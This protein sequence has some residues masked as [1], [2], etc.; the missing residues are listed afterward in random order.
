MLMCTGCSYRNALIKRDVKA[1]LTVEKCGSFAP[2]LRP[3][4]PRRM[5]AQKPTKLLH[6]ILP[7][8]CWEV[9]SP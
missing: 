7:H 3:S 6:R 4:L 9:V 5:T 1:G 2:L 8:S